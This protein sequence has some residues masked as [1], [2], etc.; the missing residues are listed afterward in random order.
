MYR[1]RMPLVLA[2]AAI[3]VL[4]SV[5]WFVSLSKTSQ[6]AP[7]PSSDAA[8]RG[9]VLLVHSNHMMSVFLLEKAQVQRIG[10]RSCLVG[11]GAADGRMLGWYKGRTMWL[12]ME[13]IVSIT[14]FDDVQSAKKALESWGAMPYGVAVE[15]TPAIAPAPPPPA[16][17]PAPAI[18]APPPAVDRPAKR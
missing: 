16:V 12:P 17:A 7:A 15:A 13:H 9:K 3:F 10:D 6:A 2:F 11:K 5:G 1:R 18:P 14:E 8:F 4:G